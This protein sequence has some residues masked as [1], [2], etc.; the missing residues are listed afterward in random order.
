MA[1]RREFLQW[2]AALTATP[3]I[4]SAEGGSAVQP[5]RKRLAILV[6][7]GTGFLGPHQVR[8]ALDRGH[9][10]TLFNRGRSAPGLFGSDVEVLL[11][12]RDARV[13]PGLTALR[14]ARRWDVVIDNSGYV[15]RHVRDSTELLQHRCDRYVFVSTVAA[16]DAPPGGGRLDESAPLRAA[17]LPETETVSAATYGALKA[18]CDRTVQARLGRRATIVR[19]TFI[20]GPG[21]DTDRFTYWVERAARGGQAL[22]P[23]DPEASL[24][25]VDV[26][27]LCP[28]LVELAER[29][30]SSIFNAAGPSMAWRDVLQVLAAASSRPV[31]WRWA[32]HEVLQRTGI[33]LPL[34]RPAGR[35]ASLHFDGTRA[36]AAGLRYRPLA[37]TAAA[38]LEWWRSQPAERRANPEDWPSEA[39]E[40]EALRLLTATGA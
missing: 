26:R 17:P 5:A 20:V 1:T 11:G 30:V 39:Q 16:Y 23:P 37:D 33:A 3:R 21:D 29:D 14:G 35:G 7:G 18:E 28:W 4:A 25:W 24:Q 15:P 8:H 38:T 40:R 19:P 22:A 6:L 9:R 34:V 10:V 13:A 27:D 2:L 36:H 12:D 32:T 31:E